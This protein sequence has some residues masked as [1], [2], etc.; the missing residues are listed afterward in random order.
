MSFS[1]AK[2][3]AMSLAMGVAAMSATAAMAGP[4]RLSDAQYIAAARCEGLMQSAALGRQDTGGLE[5]MLEAQSGGRE[6]VVSYLADEAR[7]QAQQA[8][9]HSGV[10]GKAALIAERDGASCRAL[11]GAPTVAAA[12]PAAGTP[13]TN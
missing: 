1:K 6:S 13:R 11:V 3:I 12:A 2:I 8:A 10:Y 7:E 5:K 9:R 4:A